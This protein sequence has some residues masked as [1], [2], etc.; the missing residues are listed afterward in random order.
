[1]TRSALQLVLEAALFGMACLPLAAA[2][3]AR[4]SADS[5]P[6]LTARQLAQSKHCFDCHD[7]T[8]PRV[9]PA[10]LD[11][12]R[13]FRGLNNAKP[14]LA[15]MIRT[16]TDNEAVFYH[17][18]PSRMPADSLRVPVSEEEAQ[19]LAEYILSFA[20]ARPAR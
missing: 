11:L 16:G 7:T 14:M 13:R 5:R 4:P 18:S 3:S 9:G 1:M 20:P 15:S 8:K 2:S 12:A 17:W 6:A 10:F 19:L